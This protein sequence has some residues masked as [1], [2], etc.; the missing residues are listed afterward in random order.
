M[1]ASEY[2]A[3]CRANGASGRDTPD[4][5]PIFGVDSFVRF[6]PLD[7]GAQRNNYGRIP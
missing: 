2:P 4:Q 3:A 5:N 1:A 7:A 6:L